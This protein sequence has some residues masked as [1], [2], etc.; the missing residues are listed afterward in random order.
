MFCWPAADFH[1]IGSCVAL[2]CNLQNSN[3]KSQ[4][5]M[6]HLC[7]ISSQQYKSATQR[8][9]MGVCEAGYIESVEQKKSPVKGTFLTALFTSVV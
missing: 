1:G 3:S 2:L 9:F 6:F 8:C 5:C 7:R 4:L